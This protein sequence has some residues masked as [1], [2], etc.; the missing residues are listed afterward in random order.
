MESVERWWNGARGR[1]ARRD[2]WLRTDGE[3]WQVELLVGGVEGHS[4]HWD[5]SDEA[6]ARG[7]LRQLVEEEGGWRQLSAGAW[8]RRDRKGH[9]SGYGRGRGGCDKNGED[10]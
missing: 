8:G 2:V 5:F 10:G 9:D 3:R 6:E 7:L 4:S 1:L